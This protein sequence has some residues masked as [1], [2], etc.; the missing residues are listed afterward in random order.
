MNPK[1][2]P[3]FP[4]SAWDL[5]PAPSM[6]LV[7]FRPHF[8]SHPQQTPDEAQI[9]RFYALTPV[10][11]RALVDD[12]QRALHVLENGVSPKRGGPTH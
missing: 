3:I 12:L 2:I 6:D 7:T 4:V 8:L 11:A 9:S 5:G 1:D 10:Q